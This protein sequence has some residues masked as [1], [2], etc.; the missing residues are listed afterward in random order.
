LEDTSSPQNAAWKWLVGTDEVSWLGGDEG[1]T[2]QDIQIV[3]T[4]YILAVFYYTLGGRSWDSS[5]GW[6]DPV[7]G[8][9]GWDVVYRGNNE[10]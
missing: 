4:R 6:I 7:L 9:C 5:D 2:E 1:M 8:H 3:V 10:V